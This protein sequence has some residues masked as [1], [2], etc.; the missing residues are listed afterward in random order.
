[1]CLTAR[2]GGGGAG[3][4]FSAG[5]RTLSPLPPGAHPLPMPQPARGGGGPALVGSRFFPK[6]CFSL[7]FSSL[8]PPGIMPGAGGRLVQAAEKMSY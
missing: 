5:K 1:M 8:F 7:L 3:K 4:P 6:S 2:S